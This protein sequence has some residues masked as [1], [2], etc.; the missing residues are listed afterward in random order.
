MAYKKHDR[1]A[2][3]FYIFNLKNRKII[4][5][6]E[7]REDAN[8][9][10]KE[11]TQSDL[12]VYTRTY[13]E[14]IKV[15]PSFN[16]SW[17]SDRSLGKVKNYPVQKEV[18]L[19]GDFRKDIQIPEIK[20]RFNKGKVFDKINNSASTAAFLKRVYGR[21]IDL[22]E[23]FV[24]LLFDNS[25]NIIGYYKHTV[26][27]PVSTLADIPMLIGVALKA[28]A[29]S[30]IV[31]HNHPSGN[32]KPSQADID[33]TKQINKA[34]KAVS[35]SFL[36]HI[37]I[38]KNNGY[39]SLADQG[40]MSLSGLGNVNPAKIEDELR[41][42]VFQQLK[43]ASENPG[44]TPNISKLLKTKSGYEWMERRI[45]QMMIN[46]SI[47]ASACIPQIESEL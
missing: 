6:F 13:L 28:M 20:V 9:R 24:L 2:Y 44:M 26:G 22:Q 19:Y 1:K 5:G 34:A 3:Q 39:T 37:I 30:I 36:D 8:E 16:K 7:Y 47:T 29:R 4:E 27:T 12:K 15:D 45:I 31:S 23:H 18:V 14:R 42:E 32:P 11:Y 38:T 10:K 35:I 40:L 41:F 33:L 17:G 43:K 25:L 21:S 46:D